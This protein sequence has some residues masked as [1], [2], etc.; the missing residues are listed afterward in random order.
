MVGEGGASKAV[1]GAAVTGAQEKA[2]GSE[3]ESW[4]AQSCSRGK[5]ETEVGE[6]QGVIQ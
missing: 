2:G 4:E 5:T 6:E 1:T 3:A